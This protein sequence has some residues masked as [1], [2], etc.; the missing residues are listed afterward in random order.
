MVVA[1]RDT[2]MAGSDA[3]FCEIS[4]RIQTGEMATG[5]QRFPSKGCFESSLNIFEEDT[6][7]KFVISTKDK[8]FGVD[9]PKPGSKKIMWDLQYVPFDRIPFMVVGRRVYSCHQGIDKHKHEKQT[10]QLQLLDNHS[11]HCYKE[12]RRLLQD[13]KKQ[14]CPDRIYVVHLIRFPDY[15]ITDDIH[16]QMK[17]SAGCL[18]R[19]LTTN[20]SAVKFKEQYV[21]C[22]PGIKEHKNHPVVGEV[23]C[24]SFEK[25][26][27]IYF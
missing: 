2:A 26:A 7:T 6:M 5:Y 8:A 12:R 19:A 11:D 15:K 16:K 27:I 25:S 14:D 10:R 13:S 1:R 23:S 4:W 3:I 20:P 22:F 21:A 24:S 17:E 18:K 9:D